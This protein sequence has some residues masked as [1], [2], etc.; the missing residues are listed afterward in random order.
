MS[1]SYFYRWN[2]CDCCNRY[3]QTHIGTSAGGFI[4]RAWPHEEKAWGIDPE[5][6][7]GRPVMS[8]ADWVDVMATVEGEV[9]DEYGHYHVDG[10][11]WVRSMRPE[12]AAYESAMN[13]YGRPGVPGAYGY[14]DPEG[15][16]FSASDFS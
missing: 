1:T 15:F 14:V 9:W 8:R 2:P 11:Q 16:P 13:G 10:H 4:F 7:F 5:S 6:P 3:E 12:R